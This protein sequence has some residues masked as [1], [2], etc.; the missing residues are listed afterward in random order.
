MKVCFSKWFYRRPVALA[1]VGVLALAVLSLIP[2]R[3]TVARSAHDADALVGV[4]HVIDGDTLEIAGERVRLE[5]IDAP[6]IAQTCGRNPSGTWK[7]GAAAADRLAELVRG[8]TVTCENRGYDKYGRVL[9]ICFVDG[10]DMNAEMVREGLAWA[11]VRYSQT[12]VR[13]EAQARAA[14]VGIWQG[15]AAPAWEY[16]EHRWVSAED[17][18]PSGCAIKGN[19][20]AHGRIYYMPWSPWYGNVKIEPEKGERW[21]CSEGQAIAAGWRPV[22]AQ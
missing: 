12:Y 7:C 4:A 13:E 3:T 1:L 18:A 20:T 17:G 9:G 10:H 2:L 21:F 11:F 6:E 14:R 8:H 5:G 15:E 19:I 22:V 16:R